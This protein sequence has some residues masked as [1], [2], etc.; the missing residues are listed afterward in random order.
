MP[1]E[2]P[3]DVEWADVGESFV[4]DLERKLWKEE[5]GADVGAWP[6]GRWVCWDGPE[7]VK[8]EGRVEVEESWDEMVEAVGD[9]VPDMFSGLDSRS[10]ALL[11]ADILGLGAAEGFSLADLLCA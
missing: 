8:D 11:V 5:R 9:D 10:V 1:I 3:S 6:C 7:L 4:E 2:I